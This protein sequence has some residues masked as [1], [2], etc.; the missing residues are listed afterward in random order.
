MMKALTLEQMELVN[1]GI[2]VGL[3]FWRKVELVAYIIDAKL[4]NVSE[5]DFIMEEPLDKE[6][7]DFVLDVWPRI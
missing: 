6:E 5:I 1:G 2:E 7:L 3:S 4:N